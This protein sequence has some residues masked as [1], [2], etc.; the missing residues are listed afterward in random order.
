MALVRKQL[1]AIFTA[2]F[3]SFGEALECA[4]ALTAIHKNREDL[5][6]CGAV[7]SGLDRHS[8]QDNLSQKSVRI[9]A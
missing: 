7:L 5:I 2:T 1:I 4:P 8:W 6:N 9:S 3:R